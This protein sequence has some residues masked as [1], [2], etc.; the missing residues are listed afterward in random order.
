MDYQK[1]YNQIINRAKTRQLEGYVERHHIIPKCLDGKDDN[2]NIV[3]L[4]AREH[5]ICHQLLVE[6]YPNNSKLW[7]S[8]FLM[9]INKNKKNHQK[10]NISSRNYERIKTEWNKYSKGKSKPIGFGDRIKSKNRNE[11]IGLSNSKPKPIGFG[12][13]ISKINT[14]KKR[15]KEFKNNLIYRQYKP[16]LQYDLQGNFIKEWESGTIAGNELG[17]N[18]ST[19]A[20]NAR[21]NGINKS[22]GGFIWKYKN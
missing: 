8:L 17:I 16:I 15:S 1:I 19:I 4:T 12:E 21:N 5:F 3:Q 2:I 14:G 6:I 7:Y 11:K 20:G 18:K 10:Y 13:N 22:A 9:S